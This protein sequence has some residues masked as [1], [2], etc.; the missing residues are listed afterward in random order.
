MPSWTGEGLRP[1]GPRGDNRHDSRRVESFPSPEPFGD[2]ERIAAAGGISTVFGSEV[3]V[4][5]GIDYDQMK[6]ALGRDVEL[7]RIDPSVEDAFV[8]LSTVSSG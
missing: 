4:M 5:G 1:Q 6:T 2:S 8:Y 7:R 3:H